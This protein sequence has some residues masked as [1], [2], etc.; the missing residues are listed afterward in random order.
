MMTNAKSTS[1]AMNVPK[2]KPRKKKFSFGQFILCS[3]MFLF[4]L[5][6]IIPFLNILARSLSDP[7]LAVNISGL[8]IIP[9]GFS[10]INYEIIFSHPVFLRSIY[11]GFYIAIMGLIFNMG[12]TIT[13]AYV[14]TRPRLVFKR[15][16]LVFL[17][18]MMLFDPGIIPEYLTMMQLNLIGSQWAVILVT[19]V[20]VWN[21]FILMRI[22]NGL[23]SDVIESAQIDG[24]GHF[25]ILLGIM[26]PLA[27]PGIATITMFY[28]V[29]RWNEFF[30]TGIYVTSMADTTLQV[31][32]RQ[33]VVLNDT[34]AI[35]GAGGGPLME[36]LARID[37]TSL[38][39]A[40]IIVALI[41]IFM[42]Y[43]FVLRYYVKDIMGGSIKE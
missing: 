23:P 38:Q 9:R 24:A 39:N 16:I 11:N 6:I 34:A 1:A 15:I 5:T 14:L 40:T 26:I 27:K 42:F 41:P 8:E 43:P 32:L 7:A 33:F 3:A 30:R 35:I 29:A 36:Q 4:A 22:F 25:R 31:I 20:N 21:L 12:L 17:I 10:L 13:A 37:I 19:A 18:C 2:N 28:A